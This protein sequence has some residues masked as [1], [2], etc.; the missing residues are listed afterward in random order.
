MNELKRLLGDDGTPWVDCQFLFPRCIA[1]KS[2]S[3]PEQQSRPE[4]S[5]TSLFTPLRETK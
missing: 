4:G 2:T 3:D 1:S 5:F